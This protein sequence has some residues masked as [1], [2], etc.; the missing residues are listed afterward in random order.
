MENPFS[1]IKYKLDKIEQLI[2]SNNT[3]K[4]N[5]TPIRDADEFMG[6]KQVADLLGLAKPTIYGLVHKRKIPFMKRG[7]KLYFSK[8]DVTNWIYTTGTSSKDEI[9]NL[10]NDYVLSRMTKNGQ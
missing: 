4:A 6:I 9:D 5:T 1:Q 3:K 2:K 8:K 7:K 10:A